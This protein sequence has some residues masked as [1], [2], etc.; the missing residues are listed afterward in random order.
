VTI[1]RFIQQAS[2]LVVGCASVCGWAF[3]ARAGD[4]HSYTDAQGVVHMY[5][6]RAHKRATALPKAT[7][8]Q[9]PMLLIDAQ[10]A[11]SAKLQNLPAA[12]VKAVIQTE[13]NYNPSAVS[14]KGAI[15]LMQLMPETAREMFVEDPYDWI[16]NIEGGTRYLRYLVNEFDGDINKVLAA[17]NAG[18]DAVIRNGTAENLGI[19]PIRETIE[20]VLKVSRAFQAFKAQEQGH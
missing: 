1:A 20:Y 10:I 12:L 2:C 5:N 3:P 4:V 19:P 11:R 9:I 7:D 13:S 14:V 18:P 15:G 16:Q 17:Y 6:A 8:L